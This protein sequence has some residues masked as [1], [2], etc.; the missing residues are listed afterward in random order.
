ME[1]RLTACFVRKMMNS[2]KVFPITLVIAALLLGSVAVAE[3]APSVKLSLRRD[4]GYGGL[5]NDI[6][7]SF[8]AIATVSSDVVKVEFY[9]NQSLTQTVTGA[10]F[11]WKFDTNNY[12][13]GLYVIS[14]K[15][16]DASGASATSSVTADFVKSPGFPSWVI[17]VIVAAVAIIVVLYRVGVFGGSS[18]LGM[19]RCP[20]CGEVFPRKWSP[21]HMLGSLLNTC[22]KCGKRFFAGKLRDTEE[23]PTK[24]EEKNVSEEDK[25]REDLERSKYEER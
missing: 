5:G 8:T 7:G 10:P 21:I 4:W 25:L 11:E 12:P 18:S 16:Y 20:N 9:L 22:P 14:A 1:I 3:A 19:T 13:L 23:K 6:N 24:P 15:A 17:G 2:H